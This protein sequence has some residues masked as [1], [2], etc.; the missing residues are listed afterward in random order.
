MNKNFLS[1]AVLVAV[2]TT[3]CQSN[4]SKEDWGKT[5]GTLGGAALGAKLSDDNKWLG[6]AIGAAAGYF[7]GQA[8]GRYLNEP[9]QKALAA[10]TVS[11]LDKETAGTTTWKS[12]KTGAS[13]NIK[14]GAISYKTQPQQVTHLAKVKAVPDIKVENRE[15]QSKSA[16]RVR[17]GPG[18]NYAVVTTLS[19][20]DIV[21]SAGRTPNDWLM[22]AKQGVTVGYVHSNFVAPYNP[23][24]A[25]QTQGI[26]L[27]AVE[28]D[29]LPK[30]EGFRGVDL[31]A[32]ETTT[33]TVDTQLG[34]RDIEISVNSDKGRDT[35]AT[36]A[37]QR[38]DGVWEL[39]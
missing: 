5:I 23:L 30:Q 21:T 16:L 17:Q 22:L 1:A 11:A 39:G 8:I 12:N 15:Y 9:D 6:A 32:M 26:D 27:D 4:M 34:C 35:E 31:D 33:S 28:V 29:K 18:T 37:C 14:T 25:A 7:A 2:I 3:G 13:A 20:G 38:K 24:H 36:Q 19:R 10:D